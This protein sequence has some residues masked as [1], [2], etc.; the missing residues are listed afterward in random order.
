[1]SSRQIDL[2]LFRIFEAVMAERNVTRAAKRLHMTQPAVSNAL[3]RLRDIMHDDLFIKHP[4]GVLPTSKAEAIWPEVRNSLRQLSDAVLPGEFDPACT[5]AS[6]RISGSDYV[7]DYLF[8]DAIHALDEKAPG[9]SLNFVPHTLETAVPLLESGQIDIAAGVVVNRTPRI[10]SAMLEDTRYECVMRRDHPLAGKR[11]TRAAFLDARHLA[12]SQSGQK[13]VVDR[14]L[15]EQGVR[16][17]IALTINQFALVPGILRE[18][19]LIAVVPR[20]IVKEHGAFHVAASPIPLKAQRISLLWHER[21]EGELAHRWLRELL[22]EKSRN[23][24]QSA[25]R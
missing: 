23:H 25:S 9:V 22:I 17:T 20:G 8:N 7:V 6:F 14:D 3:N 15:E 10:V 5:H 12:V 1:M 13:S 24:S 16:R 4:G 18:T 11:L 21:N 19:N 2:N